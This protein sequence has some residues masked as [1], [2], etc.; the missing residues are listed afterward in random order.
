MRRKSE[1]LTEDLKKD[2]LRI[3][4]D[5]KDFLAWLKERSVELRLMLSIYADDKENL[6]KTQAKLEFIIEILAVMN[7]KGDGKDGTK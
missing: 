5:Q 1:E 3:L 4:Q 6:I 2:V 7:N